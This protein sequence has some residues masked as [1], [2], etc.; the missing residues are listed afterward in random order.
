ML[1][2]R[3]WLARIAF[4]T[5][6]AAS[7]LIVVARCGLG[8]WRIALVAFSAV[9][10]LLAYLVAPSPAKSEVKTSDLRPVLVMMGAA[11]IA[12]SVTGGLASPML[13][14]LAGPLLIGWTTFRRWPRTYLL[15]ALVPLV[16]L[17][18]LIP[19]SFAPAQFSRAD[20]AVLAAWTT[21]LVG[22]MIGLRITRMH[23]ALCDAARRLHQIREGA[24]SDAASRRKGLESMTTKLAHELK[25]PL[26][27]I[28][29]LTQLELEHVRDDKTKRR[30]DVVLAET[31]RISAILREY[32]DRARPV[33]DVQIQELQLEELMTEIATLVAGRAE[34]AGVD[35]S[36]SGAGGS[37]RGDA[38]LLKEALVNIT[39]NAI[40][41]TPR[42]GF[43]DV[44]YHLGAAGASITVRDSGKGMSKDVS[45]RVGTP[46]FTT[47]EGGTGL[48]VVI[49]KTAIAQHGGHLDYTS[50]PGVGTIATIA[51]PIAPQQGARP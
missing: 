51:L 24:L 32:L 13:P 29:S 49:A 8:G 16:V 20:I 31:E 34:A 5:V 47:R 50:T 48:G 35:L 27:A 7:E 39:S 10:F 40:E 33:E 18:T 19:A 46:F 3:Q 44:T 2:S 6:L 36:V 37:L 21:F 17:V 1:T 43:V 25:N 28:K 14:L 26:A 15:H 22:W 42:G 30:L 9:A 11:M 38:R 41:A 23:E 4:V 12:I 45:A